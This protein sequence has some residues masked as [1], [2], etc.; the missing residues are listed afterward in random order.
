L[1]FLRGY[2]RRSHDIIRHPKKRRGGSVWISN[3]LKLSHTELRLSPQS[4]LERREGIILVSAS[5]ASSMI[6]DWRRRM[7]K[8]LTERETFSKLFHCCD[9]MGN[10]HYL[11]LSISPSPSIP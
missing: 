9:W 11:Y 7:E 3:F 6:N 10:N 4:V 8:P 1:V 5:K 2:K